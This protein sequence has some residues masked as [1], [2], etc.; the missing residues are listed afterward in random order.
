M[1]KKIIFGLLGVALVFHFLIILSLSVAIGVWHH[2]FRKTS[3]D[4]EDVEAG[5]E[6]P[7]IVNYNFDWLKLSKV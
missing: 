4:N 6:E 5:V 1:N 3:T 7:G 2:E